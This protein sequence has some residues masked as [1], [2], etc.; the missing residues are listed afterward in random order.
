MSKRRMW[1]ALPGVALMTMALAAAGCGTVSSHGAGSPAADAGTDGLVGARSG[2]WPAG[3]RR[4][5]H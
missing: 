3:L 4:L 1:A 5:A 2:R